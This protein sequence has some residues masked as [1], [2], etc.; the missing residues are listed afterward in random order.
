MLD[1]VHIRSSRRLLPLPS[2][3]ILHPILP[4]IYL[5]PGLIRFPHMF[6]TLLILL[7]NNINLRQLLMHSSCL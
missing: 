3:G 7:P 1:S 2:T 4:L 6:V 5:T